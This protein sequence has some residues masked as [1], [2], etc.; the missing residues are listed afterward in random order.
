[1][2]REKVFDIEFLET[3]PALVDGELGSNSV[4]RYPQITAKVLTMLQLRNG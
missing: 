4:K 2:G 3:L 1:M